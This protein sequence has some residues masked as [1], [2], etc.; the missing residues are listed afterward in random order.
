MKTPIR[1]TFVDNFTLEIL[2]KKLLETQPKLVCFSVPFPGNL[3]SAF[4][5][6]QYIKNHYPNIKTAF[7]G[8]LPIQNS[9]I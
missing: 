5:C 8:V 7:G 9:E 2:D 6:A 4:R 3:Y 1:K